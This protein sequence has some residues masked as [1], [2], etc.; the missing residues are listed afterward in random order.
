[1]DHYPEYTGGQLDGDA[2]SLLDELTRSP[3]PPMS[4]LSLAQAR[5]GFLPRAW[6]GVP[7]DVAAI[8][9]LDIPG[10]GGRI[11]L[12]AYVP[13]GRPPFP[14]LAFFH[15][16]GF[17]MGALPEFDTFCT[18]VAAGA[19]CVVVSAGYR[20]APEHKAPAAADDAVVVT[21][22]LADHA[23]ELE[24]DPRRIAVAGDSAG[25]NLAAVAAIAARDEGGPALALQVLLSPWVDLSSCDTASFRLFGSGPWLSTASIGWCRDHYLSS[26]EQAFSLTVSPLLARDLGRLPPAL[27]V[28][29]ELDVLRDQVE[30]YARRLEASGNAV[31]YRV[32][33]G[34][35]HDF[36]I[37][38]ALFRRAR[39]AI[40]DV[41]SALRE[42]FGRG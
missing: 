25:G 39:E 41:C 13:R 38:P 27:I 21:R 36:A 26:P 1:M 15:G 11:A 18:Y 2:Q 32:Y 37:F 33:P 30:A 40:D 35:L 16:G 31:T 22:W 42:A 34:T 5:A 9:D 23:A 24:G 12:R 8:R 7:M 4:T 3:S 20:L 10:P 19:G 14:V 29:A 6:Q 28:N 17:A